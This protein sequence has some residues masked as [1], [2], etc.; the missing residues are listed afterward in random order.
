MAAGMLN[1][2][3]IPGRVGLMAQ[4]RAVACVKSFA[5]L[6]TRLYGALA[7]TIGARAALTF[8]E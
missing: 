8:Q 3:S 1:K 5:R 4:A 2:C 7:L 6:S